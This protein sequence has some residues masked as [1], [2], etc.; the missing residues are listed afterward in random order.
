MSLSSLISK[1]MVNGIPKIMFPG[2][3]FIVCLVSKQPRLSFKSNLNKRAKEVLNAID[4]DICGPFDVHSI[5]GDNY[6]ITF[7]DKYSRMIWM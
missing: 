7:V 1:E 6:F 4:F 3:T 2:N 5:D